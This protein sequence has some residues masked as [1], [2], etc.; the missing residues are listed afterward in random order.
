MIAR[1]QALEVAEQELA[2]TTITGEP[3][4][5]GDDLVVVAAFQAVSRGASQARGPLTCFVCDEQGHMW[6]NCVYRTQVREYI[7]QLKT[8][9]G[10][11]IPQSGQSPQTALN[12]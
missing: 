7:R 9:P 11:C 12:K 1:V 3:L 10:F 4:I 2:R 6:R 5:Y 8:D